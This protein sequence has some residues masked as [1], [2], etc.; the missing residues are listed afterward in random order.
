MLITINNLMSLLIA[1]KMF[2]TGRIVFAI[3][4]IIVFVGFMIF[5]YIKDAKS[6]SIHYKNTAKY[7]GIAL[8][9]TIAV[10]ILSKYIF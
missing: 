7:V 3:C 6:H 5:S 8:I 1:T 2:T 4:F 9:T 10:L